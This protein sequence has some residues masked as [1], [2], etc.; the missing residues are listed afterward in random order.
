MVREV[1]KDL[2]DQR[3]LRHLE[4]QILQLGHQDP[5][6]QLGLNFLANQKALEVQEVLADLGILLVLMI[7][8][9][10][11]LQYLQLSL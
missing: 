6:D 1:Q 8:H 2:Q 11:L 10:Q 7:P 4:V 5:K 9:L 3:D